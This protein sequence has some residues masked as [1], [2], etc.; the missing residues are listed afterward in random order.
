LINLH[1][2]GV[3]KAGTTALASFLS[4]HP[5]IYVVDGKEA[6][7]FDHPHYAKQA[8]KT[9][10]A[11][12]KYQSKLSSYQKQSIVCD[13]TPITVFRQDYL[14]AC[15]QYNPEAKFILILRDPVERAISHYHMSRNQKLESRSMLSAFL[16]EPFRLWNINKSGSWE[17]NSSFRTQSYLS[18]GCYSKQLTSLFRLIPKQ[19]VL[20]LEQQDLSLQHKATMLKIFTF[21]DIHRHPIEPAKIFATEKP[22]S[23]WSD[24]LA[25]MYARL[26][27]KCHREAPKNWGKIINS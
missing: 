27:Y 9:V 17:F 1:I 6:H 15:Y 3:Q 20:V 18:R 11:H 14:Q 22:S 5:A 26:Y 21:L 16:L 13:A 25:R 23:H 24:I 7:V 2:I 19:Q 8:N 4:Q 12:K 10:F